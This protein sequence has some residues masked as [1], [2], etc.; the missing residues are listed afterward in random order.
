MIRRFQVSMFVVSE[1]IYSPLGPKLLQVQFKIVVPEFEHDFAAQVALNS[2][3][4][5]TVRMEEVFD[6]L[7]PTEWKVIEGNS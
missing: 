6:T 5:V 3:C 1:Q 4:Q 7:E 2:A